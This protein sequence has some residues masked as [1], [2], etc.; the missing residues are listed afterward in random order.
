MLYTEMVMYQNDATRYPTALKY[1]QEII[2]SGSYKLLDNY[3]NIWK[4]SG[5]WSS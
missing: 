2:N 3:A 1:M 5:E 4:E